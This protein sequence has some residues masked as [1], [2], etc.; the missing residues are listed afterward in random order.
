VFQ[1]HQEERQALYQ[2]HQGLEEELLEVQ[3]VY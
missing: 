3:L 1:E 2:E